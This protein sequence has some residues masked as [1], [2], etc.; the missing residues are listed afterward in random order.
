MQR[1]LALEQKAFSGKT[2]ARFYPV[3]TRIDMLI[4]AMFAREVVLV[5]QAE[6][7]V[8]VRLALGRGRTAS[9]RP[10][11]CQIGAGNAPRMLPA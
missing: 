8:P 5:R 6:A 3:H 7:A 9:S 11:R 10:R 1:A 2:V 4:D